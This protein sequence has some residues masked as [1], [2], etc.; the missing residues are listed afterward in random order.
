M[1]SS[2]KIRPPYRTLRSAPL[3]RCP[4]LIIRFCFL[5][6][7]LSPYLGHSL[8]AFQVLYYSND[9][10][11][12]VH[13][14][15][16]SIAPSPSPSPSFNQKSWFFLPPSCSI[17]HR[18]MLYHHSPHSLFYISLSGAA[19]FLPCYFFHP[20][21]FTPNLS[22]QS[23]PFSLTT[24]APFLVPNP[25]SSLSCIGLGRMFFCVCVCTQPAVSVS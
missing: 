22:F 25:E 8:L 16:P 6:L 5:S 14:A 15:F 13:L 12:L 11:L 3:C 21:R 19:F 18:I 4:V 9:S 20:P 23:P 10:L 2:T 7:P 24:K 1:S 17:P